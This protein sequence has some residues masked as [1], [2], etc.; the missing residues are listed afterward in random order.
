MHLQFINIFFAL[1]GS[2]LFIL[3]CLTVAG[4]VPCGDHKKSPHTY[5]LCRLYFTFKSY[6]GT[7][8]S[9]NVF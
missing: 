8:R 7:L 9:K 4:V 1:K 2:K 6:F 5:H 3:I